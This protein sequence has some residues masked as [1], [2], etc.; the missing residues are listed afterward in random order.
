MDA[1]AGLDQNIDAVIVEPGPAADHEDDM[2]VGGVKME[3]G[4]A[5]RLGAL[6][7]GAHQLH[8]NF[9]VGGCGDPRVPVDEERA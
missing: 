1:V 2:N 5:F 4:A 3:A 7:R 8:Q 6:A 9:A